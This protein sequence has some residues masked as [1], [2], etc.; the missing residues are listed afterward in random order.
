[1]FSCLPGDG[2][3]T[4]PETL[5]FDL[6]E[7]VTTVKGDEEALR[8]HLSDL[9]EADEKYDVLKSVNALPDKYL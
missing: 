1:M 5:T 4:S 7:Y 6:L 9:L 2:Q 3:T 8:Y